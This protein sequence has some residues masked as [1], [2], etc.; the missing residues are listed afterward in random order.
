VK[1]SNLIIIIPCL[2]IAAY[3]AYKTEHAKL[4]HDIKTAMQLQSVPGNMLNYGQLGDILKNEG[5]VKAVPNDYDIYQKTNKDNLFPSENIFQKKRIIDDII[6]QSNSEGY[7][8]F[9]STQSISPQ[10]IDQGYPIIAI[11][12]PNADLYS[13]ASGIV[14][15]YQRRGDDWERLCQI[16]YFDKGILQF[17]TSAGLRLHG[18]KSRKL[19]SGLV[20]DAL[21]A[22]A[23]NK[24]SSFRFYF[25]KKYGTQA[26]KPNVLFGRETYPIRTLVLRNMG[27]AKWPFKACMGFDIADQIGSVTPLHTPVAIYLNGQ[28]YGV[29][30]LAEHLSVKQWTARLGH[31]QFAMHRYKGTSDDATKLQY[32]QLVRWA[33]DRTQRLSLK[34]AAGRIDIDNFTNYLMTLMYT[35]VSDGLQGAALLD[36]STATPVWQWI[37]WDLTNVKWRSPKTDSIEWGFAKKGYGGLQPL[38]FSRLLQEDPQYVTYFLDAITDLV[39][40]RISL[41][42]IKNR[43]EYYDNLCVAFAIKEGNQLAGTPFFTGRPRTIFASLDK[44]FKIGPPIECTI[45]FPP[46]VQILIDNHLYTAAYKGLYRKGAV[47]KL[48]IPK[49]NQSQ[50]S[51]WLINGKKYP[52]QTIAINVQNNLNIKCVLINAGF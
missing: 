21:V 6:F 38:I 49:Q 10:I 18:G 31:D 27:V 25:R 30:F 4:M 41:S 15:N 22:A 5:L 9:T 8:G 48:D 34:Q 40:H 26:F 52:K 33:M 1:L 32:Q 16:S 12:C 50:F 42:F 28:Q 45:D 47:L 3:L 29:G 11:T 20:G 37:N 19:K 7:N 36:M 13:L 46:T 43:I 23:K 44:Y 35:G 14:V 2:T 39:N 51:Y 17:A 24:F